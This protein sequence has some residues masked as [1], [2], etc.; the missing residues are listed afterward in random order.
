[1][2]IDEA[3]QKAKLNDKEIQNIK[4]SDFPL[5]GKHSLEKVI[6]NA[7]LRK[8]HDEC[9]WRTLEE[10]EEIVKGYQPL[11]EMS[12][13]E[14]AEKERERILHWLHMHL[15]ARPDRK[16]ATMKFT[17]WVRLKKML[18]SKQALKEKKP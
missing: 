9:G 7:Q 3:I 15:L 6:S 14:G 10:V 12:F 13:E 2:T 17:E 1:M 4:L 5:S 8:A 16:L 18:E 11:L